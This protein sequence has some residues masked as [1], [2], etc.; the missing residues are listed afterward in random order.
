MSSRRISIAKYES[1]KIET[2]MDDD[3]LER[4]STEQGSSSSLSIEISTLWERKR[5][6]LNKLK[7]III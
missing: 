5:A 6:I 2:Y 3:E 7:C 4:F 1:E